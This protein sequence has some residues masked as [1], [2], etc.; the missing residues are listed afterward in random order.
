MFQPVLT[1]RMQAKIPHF[2]AGFLYVY[3]K[4]N[5]PNEEAGGGLEDLSGDSFTDFVLKCGAFSAIVN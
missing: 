4:E 5:F 2:G 1:K 3:G